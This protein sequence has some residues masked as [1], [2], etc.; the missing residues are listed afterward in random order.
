MSTYR[1]WNTQCLRNGLV[2][3]HVVPEVGGRVVQFEVTMKNIDSRYEPLTRRLIATEVN[4]RT[5]FLS[6]FT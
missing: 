5:W 6:V 4:S 1:G 2:E 3:V